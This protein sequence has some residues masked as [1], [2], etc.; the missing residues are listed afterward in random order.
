MSDAWSSTVTFLGGG[1]IPTPG[2][3]PLGRTRRVALW[4][5]PVACPDTRNLS[6]LERAVLVALLER[7]MSGGEV[8]Y[9]LGI[10]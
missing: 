4:D 9:R 8:A 2:T 5:N 6:D 7:P 10:S 3:W 1:S